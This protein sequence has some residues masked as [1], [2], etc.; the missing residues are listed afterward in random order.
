MT[1][2]PTENWQIDMI[3]LIAGEFDGKKIDLRFR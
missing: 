1:P 3:P 2:E